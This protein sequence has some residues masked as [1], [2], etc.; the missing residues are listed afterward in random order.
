MKW[1]SCDLRVNLC[2]IS[3]RIGV[4]MLCK[5]AQGDDGQQI[6]HI[7][8]R[9]YKVSNI[10]FAYPGTQVVASK[11][12]YLWRCVCF[13]VFKHITVL[14]LQICANFLVR[15]ASYRIVSY[16]CIIST[17]CKHF[18]FMTNILAFTFI[19]LIAGSGSTGKS[20][21]NPQ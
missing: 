11:Q 3:C 15:I 16:I 14:L 13:I 8:N 5:Y 10:L 17:W 1:K 12:D 2:N 20:M 9:V 19:T 21:G 6:Y 4:L 7:L 18:N